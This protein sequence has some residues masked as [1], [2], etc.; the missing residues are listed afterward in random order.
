MEVIYKIHIP[1]VIGC[2]DTQLWPYI[3][4]SRYRTTTNFPSTK[5]TTKTVNLC[6]LL[7]VIEHEQFINSSS[8]KFS[9]K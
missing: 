9:H 2:K 1:R 8:S 6:T 7:L 4:I 5:T 3:S